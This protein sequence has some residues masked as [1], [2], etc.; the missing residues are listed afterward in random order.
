MLRTLKN[1]LGQR[2]VIKRDVLGNEVLVRALPNNPVVFGMNEGAVNLTWILERF[3]ERYGTMA[4]WKNFI[5]GSGT[6]QW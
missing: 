2:F 3:G 6:S 5:R 1:K 4:N